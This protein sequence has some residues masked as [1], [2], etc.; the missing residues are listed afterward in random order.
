MQVGNSVSALRAG[1]ILLLAF[2]RC[3][4]VDVITADDYLW[5]LHSR[6]ILVNNGATWQNSQ[7]KQCR[8]AVQT[9]SA[10]ASFNSRYA[11]AEDL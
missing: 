10:P 11:E 2:A 5:L 7:S 9:Y 8:A 1:G 6:H 3:G 4:A